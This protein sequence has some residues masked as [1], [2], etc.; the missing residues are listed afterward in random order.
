MSSSVKTFLASW[1]KKIFSKKGS[2][3]P[4]IS[5]T[6]DIAMIKSVRQQPYP[7]LCQIKHFKRFLS[8]TER[9]VYRVGVLALSIG[10]IWLGY[11][12]FLH[13]TTQVA[14]QGGD[15]VEGTVGAPSLIN[16]L[17]ASLSDVDKDLTRLIYSGLMKVDEN[18]NLVTD[19]AESMTL[20]ED[21]KTYT[22]VLKK[23]VVWH[24]GEAFTS[25]DVVF[26]FDLMQN[27]TVNSP[28]LVS[29]QGVKVAAV[30]DY[31]VTF[32]L[33]EVYTPF[34]SSLT[35]GILPEHIWSEIPVEQIRLA[36][37]NLQ[38]IGTGP[39]KFSRMVTDRSGFISEYTLERFDRYYMRPA[40]LDHF[41]FRF[42]ASY[43]GEDPATSAIEAM[44][45]QN[46]EGVNFVP[47]N[48]KDKLERKRVVLYNPQL[49]QY[50]ALFFNQKRQTVLAEKELRIALSEAID[51][52]KIIKDTQKGSAL[53][54]G[55]AILPD[56]PGFKS[57]ATG[58]IAHSLESANT[59]LDKLFD[60]VNADEQKEKRR[61][62]L[63]KEWMNAN[64]PASGT[65]STIPV[66]STSTPEM[67]EFVEN[68]LSQEFAD[69]Q[70][71]FRKSKKG[72]DI[73]V[74][75][76]VT[77]DTPEYRKAAE[78][79]VGAWQEIG[80][81]T[82]MSYI[83]AKALSRDILR[84]RKYDVLLYG[85]LLG[86]DPDQ[87]PFW[88]SSQSNYPGLNLSQYS[89]KIVDDVLKKI[90]ETEKAEEL[91]LLYRQF[92]DQILQDIPAVFLYSPQ[93]HYAVDDSI[94]GI[95]LNRIT[96]PSDRLMQVT[97][98]YKNTKRDW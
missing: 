98:W 68:T 37:T 40:Y 87:Y 43:E 81:K 62:E 73:L 52:E 21:K 91:G 38:P 48:A 90:R 92:E 27:R 84:D 57:D 61:V 95:V 94:K 24:D 28:L 26:T 23:N 97:N 49:P 29:F 74:L 63:Q 71:F 46:I 76:M 3:K 83:S 88:H 85:V 4:L 39:F 22:F 59:R 56:Y 50:T 2:P 20:S 6:L 66:V 60:R 47:V 93:Y 15:Y 36:R 89:N 10:V 17:Y 8:P 18:G 65:T 79:I 9:M 41:S 64:M 70:T 31:T 32:T 14:A 12:L 42:Y 67:I 54:I 16:P 55:G 1:W 72:G 45:Q 77:V 30:D 51:K 96:E 19:L 80:I 53:V 5:S 82:R 33:P 75:D 34:P 69:A 11:T 44:R 25:S 78:I 35:V 58:T 13:H 7:R 86:S